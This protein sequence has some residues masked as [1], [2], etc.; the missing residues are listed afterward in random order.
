MQ[1]RKSLFLYCG[2]ALAVMVAEFVAIALMHSPQSFAGGVILHLLILLVQGLGLYY[3]RRHW[4][5]HRLPLLL[6]VTTALTGPFGAGVCLL[7]GLGILCC[8][9]GETL[10][11][12]WLYESLAG[13]SSAE[14]E[15]LHDRLLLGHDELA[16]ENAVEPFQDI[17]T[18]GTV[19]QKQM[20]IAKITRYFRPPFAPLLLQASQD[21]NAAVRVQAATALARIERDFMAQYMR[22]EKSLK[23][24]AAKDDPDAIRLRLAQ[25]CDDYAYAGL[26]DEASRQTLRARAIGIYEDWLIRNDDPQLRIKL[27]RLHLR[28]GDAEKARQLLEQAVESQEN[29]GPAALLWYMEALFRLKHLGKLRE[30]AARYAKTMPQ[31]KDY[32]FLSGL[33]NVLNAWNSGAAR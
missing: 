10:A 23:A 25:L 15:R 5:D 6:L 14:S 19:L 24:P 18:S 13:E 20:A 32:K 27:A 28:Q 31:W 1:G 2:L 9:P 26:L 7:A 22:L 33:D 3:G 29:T 12:Q 16:A 30:L 21:V 4:A 17:L 11:D 8:P